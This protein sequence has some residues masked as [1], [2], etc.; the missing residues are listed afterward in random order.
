RRWR[1]RRWRWRRRLQRRRR[2]SGGC[3]EG[4]AGAQC[5][6]CIPAGRLPEPAPEAAAAGAGGA[7]DREKGRRLQAAVCGPAR[8][9]L[10]LLPRARLRRD[11]RQHRVERRGVQRDGAGGDARGDAVPRA[12]LRAAGGRGRGAAGAPRW[13]HAH[14]PSRRFSGRAAPHSGARRRDGP[15]RPPASAAAAV[16]PAQPRQRTRW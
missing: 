12:R 5:G 2:L 6:G 8:R 10:P 14:Q 1:R 15:A 9:Y 7:V 11:G 4:G 3:Q 16:A 13:L